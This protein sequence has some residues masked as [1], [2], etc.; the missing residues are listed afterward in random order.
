MLLLMDEDRK[1]VTLTVQRTALEDFTT[2]HGLN[3]TS[4]V[5][6]FSAAYDEI[7]SAADRIYD[8]HPRPKPSRILLTSHDLN[9]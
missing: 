1:I 8:R 9:G 2:R 7:V 6:M 4:S 3:M 5:E